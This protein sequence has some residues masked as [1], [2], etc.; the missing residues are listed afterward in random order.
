MLPQIIAA[1]IAAQT[2]V[3]APRVSARV[4]CDTIPAS[5]TDGSGQVYVVA[6]GDGRRVA[7]TD[8]APSGRRSSKAAMV[9]VRDAHGITHTVGRVGPG[10]GEFSFVGN[11]SWRGDTLWLSDGASMRIQA[12]TDN[13]KYL[14]GHAVQTRSAQT[15]RPGGATIGV[16]QVYDHTAKSRNLGTGPFAVVV[17]RASGRADTV[18]QVADGPTPVDQKVIP[19]LSQKLLI[20]GSAGG[21]YWCAIVAAESAKLAT[22]CTD[23]TG[24]HYL[25]SVQALPARA[26]SDTAW[27]SAVAA[28]MRSSLGIQ[29]SDVTDFFHRPALLPSGFD[30]LVNRNGDLW[31]LRTHPGEPGQIWDRIRRDGT[32]LPSITVPRHVQIR[33]LDGAWYFAADAD[34]DDLQSLIR[35][36]IQ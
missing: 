12:F 15:A 7:W 33:A 4:A 18:L 6:P 26:T 19:E 22:S 5:S 3:H 11:L 2:G 9:F 32:K 10:P 36:P 24:R 20:R 23:A 27:G 25:Q 1:L 28:M 35:C 13:G 31:I 17:T 16:E 14:I 30:L 21:E 34:A 8:A 29:R